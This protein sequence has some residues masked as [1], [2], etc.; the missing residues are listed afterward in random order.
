MTEHEPA[1]FMERYGTPLAV[2]AGAIIIAFAF[3]IGKSDGPQGQTGGAPVAV[4]IEDVSTEDTPFLGDADAPV[5]M[6]VWFDYQCSFCKQYEK[7]IDELRATHIDTGKVKVV[8]KDY[9]F[10][11]GSEEV[12]VFGRAMWDEYPD[13]YYA[14]HKAVM[15]LP[16]G[17]GSGLTVDRVTEVAA[18][19]EGVSA[20][21]VT[22]N[23]TDNREDYLEVIRADRAEGSSFG[24]TGTPGTIIG[25]E[26]LGGAQPLQVVT[27]ALDAASK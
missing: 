9:Q 24:I 18:G 1:P 11:P 25:T 15:A 7:T 27:A 14:W 23:A 13:Q 12:A 3:G 16:T 4:D 6:A 19:I 22:E 10:F 26:L 5:T 20:E 21:R 17:E 8:F 2:L